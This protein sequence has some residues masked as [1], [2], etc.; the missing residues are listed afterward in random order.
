MS[1]DMFMPDVASGARLGEAGCICAGLA[2]D[3][4]MFMPGIG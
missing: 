3:E 4:G 2:V 1:M